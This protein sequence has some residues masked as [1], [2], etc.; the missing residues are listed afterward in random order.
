MTKIRGSLVFTILSVSLL[1]L[2]V[3]F[4]AETTP[5]YKD[6]DLVTAWDASATAVDLA[7]YPDGFEIDRG[8]VYVLSGATQGGVWVNAGDDDVRLVLNSATITNPDGPAIYGIEADKIIITLAEGATNTVTDG[9]DYPMDGEEADAAI[10]TKT[11]LTINGTG[12]LSVNG[13][14]AHAVVSKDDLLIVSGAYEVTSVKDGLRGKDSISILD[15]SFVID[16]GSD[17]IVSDSEK[18]DKGT[19]TI[20]N[21]AFNLIAAR[22]GIQARGILRI[23]NGA[24]D[25]KTGEGGTPVQAVQADAATAPTAV[26]PSR[27][28]QEM[29]PD[30]AVEYAGDS[31]KGIKGDLSVTIMGGTFTLNTADDAI[32]S[33]GDVTIGGGTYAITSGDDGM[34]ADNNLVILGGEVTVQG[35]VEGLE[36]KTVDV[37]GGS[38]TVFASD[39]GINASADTADTGAGRFGMRGGNMAPQEGVLVTISG[40]TLNIQG[41]NDAIDSNGDIAIS[42]GT[43]NLTVA[44][45][46]GGSR[47]IDPNGAYTHTGGTVTTSDG[48]ENGGG[49]GFPGGGPGGQGFPGGNGFGPGRRP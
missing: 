16:A 24:F 14:T 30:D 13:Q 15:G 26:R 42:G 34:H 3:G 32:H 1:A 8:G 18:E 17:G 40:G 37:R 28:G 41:G 11:D 20:K 9:V 12:S 4:A 23:D 21:G 31:A 43:V 35:A 25:I 49:M 48:S 45:P 2:G 10:Y 5:L 33:N 22:D 46:G 29:W 38:I 27:P 44:R 19:V 39:D 36:G 6:R 47:A 7:N